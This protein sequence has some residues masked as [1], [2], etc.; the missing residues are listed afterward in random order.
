MIYQ[1][2]IDQFLTAAAAVEDLPLLHHLVRIR[3]MPQPIRKIRRAVG[4]GTSRRS[5]RS[6]RSSSPLMRSSWRKWSRFDAGYP[7]GKRLD[8]SICIDAISG[9][10]LFRQT[11]IRHAI[12]QYISDCSVDEP[13]CEC[14]R[15]HEVWRDQP[16]VF[17]THRRSYN[18]PARGPFPVGAGTIYDGSP[19]VDDNFDQLAQVHDLVFASFGL[20]GA[21][22]SGRQLPP[23]QR[24]AAPAKKPARRISRSPGL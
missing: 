10:E 6:S 4:E 23:R 24:P 15:D 20:D 11:N 5:A 21:N 22:S 3:A 13:P 18:E 8:E 9:A 14:A 7:G 1:E 19:D 2:K 16:G 17:Y 12:Q